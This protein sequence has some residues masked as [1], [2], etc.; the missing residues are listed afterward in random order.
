[1]KTELIATLANYFYSIGKTVL[2]ITPQIKPRQELEKRL[3]SRFGIDLP[4]P[5]GRLQS[6][7]TSGL[8]NR[9]DVKDQNELKKLEYELA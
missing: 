2:L 3:K 9:K 1:M 8:L 4:T 6:M 5:D 7:I